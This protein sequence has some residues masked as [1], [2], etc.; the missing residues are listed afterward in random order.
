MLCCKTNEAVVTMP[1]APVE[2]VK[3]PAQETATDTGSIAEE[4]EAEKTA[5]EKGYKCCGIY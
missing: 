1:V 5:S 3:E 2:P 4:E